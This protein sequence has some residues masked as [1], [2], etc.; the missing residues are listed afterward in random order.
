MKFPIPILVLACVSVI[1]LT[2]DCRHHRHHHRQQVAKQAVYQDPAVQRSKSMNVQPTKSAKIA[3]YDGAA[4]Q[5]TKS[6][7]IA[8]YQGAAIQPTKSARIV[9][10]QGAAI[11]PSPSPDIQGQVNQAQMYNPD[12]RVET[13]RKEYQLSPAEVRQ[14]QDTEEQQ[15]FTADE[16]MESSKR[17]G[18]NDKTP[19]AEAKEELGTT[20]DVE[21]DVNNMKS[22]L[23]KTNFD[24]LNQ[25]STAAMKAGVSASLTG[26]EAFYTSYKKRDTMG[27]VISSVS[28][29][30]GVASVVGGP[31]GNLIAIGLNV[32]KMGLSI[33]KKE[34]AA[35]VETEAQK[36]EKAIKK[37]LNEFRESQLKAEWSGYE[38][39]AD[40]FS[41]N[42]EYVEEFANL[43]STKNFAESEKEEYGIK[44]TDSLNKAKEKMFEAV[45]P[46]MYDVLMGSSSLIGK[47]EYEISQ[48]CDYTLNVDKVIRKKYKENKDAKASAQVEEDRE[49]TNT[50]F[51]ERCLGIYELYAKVNYY[52][53]VTY[54]TNLDRIN[55]IVRPKLEKGKW[56]PGKFD[57]NRLS[58]EAKIYAFIY[59]KLILNVLKHS[60]E[61]NKKLFYPF[62]N[63]F[64]FFKMRYAINNYHTYTERYEYLNK[65]IENLDFSNVEG[66]MPVAEDV[67]FCDK[68]SLLGSCH[69]VETKKTDKEVKE[70]N[71]KS[72]YLPDGK[73]VEVSYK[74]N[75]GVEPMK[76]I[77]PGVMGSVFNILKNEVDKAI[78]DP[79][80]AIKILETKEQK[81]DKVVK[82]CVAPGDY[83]E[84]P[85]PYHR[86]VC[87]AMLL[88]KTEVDKGHTKELAKLKA[89]TV[90]KGNYFS[91]A[92]EEA[93]LAFVGTAEVATKSKK[94]LK[95]RWGPFYSPREMKILC[96]SALWEKI[97]VYRYKNTEDSDAPKQKAPKDDPN[98]CKDNLLCGDDVINKQLFVKICKEPNMRGYCEEVPF[99]EKEKKKVVDL[100]RINMNI[101][102]DGKDVTH[103]DLS[104]E[105]VKMDAN[106]KLEGEDKENKKYDEKV[107]D[108]NWIPRNSRDSILRF[109]ENSWKNLLQSMK[110]PKDITV[111]LY[112]ELKGK[113]VMYGP[114][115][116]PVSVHRVDG[117]MKDS[118]IIKSMEIIYEPRKPVPV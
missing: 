78:A 111:K 23:S 61:H 56:L 99:V 50:D 71:V 81:D 13:Y 87:T 20:K 55:E 69:V 48:A 112:T 106:K 102:M 116:G 117:N 17:A 8:G 10:Y 76:M 68:P 19:E 14:L 91:V 114:Y 37:A 86:S 77:G 79:V 53:E 47:I 118:S 75:Q 95:I 21:S 52:R 73:T 63:P 103:E 82:M 83:V 110:I 72:I 39:L 5:P 45:I 58:P 7:R 92:S 113:G 29:L 64:N 30:S 24:T 25:K 67:M 60:T 100:T 3:G 27:M 33:A 36:L 40:L 46:R 54:I 28:I 6:A 18:A 4:I 108:C 109:W 62:L 9:G 88:S 107:D 101:Q 16:E 34:N 115:V 38:R 44:D 84:G 41:K 57:T 70:G 12:P 2:V 31:I 104:N 15:L 85:L 74:N 66:E 32:L 90:W 96:G 42:V 97:T 105:Y 51:S 65:Y 80:D 98:F 43:T 49:K 89:R 1:S 26:I 93:D 35:P 59:M 94:K 22:E 11:Q